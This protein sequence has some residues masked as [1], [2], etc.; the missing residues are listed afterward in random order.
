[1]FLQLY[2]Y[3]VPGGKVQSSHQTDLAILLPV[4]AVGIEL[5]L[6]TKTCSFHKESNFQLSPG[7]K[8]IF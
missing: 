8:I 2:S 6:Q 3:T 5:I 4:M 1:M 7:Q